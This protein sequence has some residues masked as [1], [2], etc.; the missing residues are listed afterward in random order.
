[1][2]V[3]GATGGL[4]TALPQVLER[5]HKY[6]GNIPAVVG[7]GVST[8]EHFL[9]VASVAEG[10]VIGSEIINRLANAPAGLGAAHIQEYCAE[11][12]G[13]RPSLNG[14]T[15]KV[16]M[17]EP[18]RDVKKPNGIKVD[19]VITDDDRGDEPGLVEQIEALNT[20]GVADPTVSLFI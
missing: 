18:Q 5:V 1:M 11:I 16:A 19:D 9:S 3:T 2:G 12:T 7:F 10:V 20:N 8:R 6:A 13:R 15:K 4:N 14:T 17:V